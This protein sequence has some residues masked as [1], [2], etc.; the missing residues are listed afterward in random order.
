MSRSARDEPARA[1][2]RRRVHLPDAASGRWDDTNRGYGSLGSYYEQKGESPGVW[3]G[4][5]LDSLD[6]S[7]PEFRVS[8]M[9]TETQMTALF[10]EGRHPNADAIERRLQREGVRGRTLDRATKLG[11]EYRTYDAN[12]FREQ[13]TARYREHNKSLDRRS[14]APIEAEVRARIRTELAR[15]MFA[16]VHARQPSD[17]RELSGFLARASRPAP[18]A[19]AGYDLTFSPVKSVSALWAIAPP[20]VSELIAQAH[21]GRRYR[22]DRLA[23]EVRRLHPPRR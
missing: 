14:A 5:G 18:V 20:E 19:V 17:G 10:G 4:S 23:R 13:L 7:V 8:G 21:P 9:V 1:L 6:G 16:E 2:G 22:H 12:P 3:L 11:Q 15:G